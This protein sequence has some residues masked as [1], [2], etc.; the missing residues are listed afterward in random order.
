MDQFLAFLRTL[1]LKPALVAWDAWNHQV[2][3]NTILLANQAC[4]DGLHY[5]FVAAVAGSNLQSLDWI[6][7]YAMQLIDELRQKEP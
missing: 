4:S 7:N 5:E 2:T 1:P 3:E 6:A